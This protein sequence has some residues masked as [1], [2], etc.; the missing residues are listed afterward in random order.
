M[1]LIP[2]MGAA[3][4]RLLPLLIV[5][6]LFAGAACSDDEEGDSLNE[7]SAPTTGA[8]RVSQEDIAELKTIAAGK[9]TACI[10]TANSPFG[11]EEGGQ[12][13][14]I[15]PELVRGLAGR[16]ALN[17]EFVPV[18][19]KDVLSAL[20][21]GRCDLSAAAVAVTEDGEKTHLFSEPYLLVYPSLLVR[22][23]DTE[24]YK[25]LDAL[26]G[27]TIGVQGGTT[28]ADYA[29]KN[30]GGATVEEFGD[31][32]NQGDLFA[33]LDAGQ[34]DAVVH[35]LPVNAY[36]ASTSAGKTVV[37]KVFTDADKKPVALAMP[38]DRADLK[39][40]IDDGLL[41]VKSDDTYPT[42]L[43][44]FLGEFA[45]QALKDVGGP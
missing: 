19:R 10:D 25:D 2:P 29:K 40:V 45:A 20:D 11:F 8:E 36:R 4:P 23:A 15:D 22:A 41:Q 32:G 26:S 5:L 44:R 43:R 21:A 13:D 9:L 14:G 34:V 7:D 31:V 12:I 28:A 17:A 39:K 3:R 16:F 27:R 1:H 24:K 35:D 30:S 18:A 33:A 42:V 38:N 6:T 37:T